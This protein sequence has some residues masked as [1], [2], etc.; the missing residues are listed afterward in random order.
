V[1][2]KNNVFFNA[3]YYSKQPQFDAVYLNFVNE[4]NPD[5]T[6]EKVLGL[7]LGYGLNLGDFRTKINVYRTSWK[8]RFQSISIETPTGDE[9]NAN[10][11]G[12]EQIHQGIEIE[13]NYRA[14]DVIQFRGML[15]L[16]D[17]EYNGNASGAALDDERNVIDPDVTLYLDGV[18]VGDAEQF[19]TNLEMIIRPI[20]NLKLSANVYSASRLYAQINADDFDNADHQGSLR[21]PSYSL[22]DF[23]AYYKFNF[24]G[25]NVISIA[26]NL[27]NAF[28]TEYIAESLTNTFVGAGDTTFRGLN[29][30]NKVFFGFGRT[31][32]VSARYT[33]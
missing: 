33:F 30:S 8:D 10:I 18:K 32:N 2:E 28:D 5:L 1:N 7:E 13:A 19:T 9:G 14:S 22:M 26:A 23:G 15:S 31:F 21:L 16:G 24:G 11:T 27:N 6:N 3:G 20:E 12:I 17:W 25:S 29:T 4:L